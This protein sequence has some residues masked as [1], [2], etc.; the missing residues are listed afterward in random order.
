MR[1]G[2]VENL[3]MFYKW[4]CDGSGS[5]SQYKQRFSE[6]YEGVDEHKINKNDGYI[7]IYW[8]H[9]LFHYNFSI[10]LII[11]KRLFYDKIHDQNQQNIVVQFEYRIQYKK[12][13]ADV[14]ISEFDY[15]EKQ[16]ENLQEWSE[17]Y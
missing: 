17:R 10:R 6:N 3:Q 8:L 5:H 14:T 13:T 15:I 11:Q 12:E 1:N 9:G 16:I 4:G 7:Y 2:N